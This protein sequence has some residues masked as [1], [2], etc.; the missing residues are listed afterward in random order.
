[1]AGIRAKVYDNFITR[2]WPVQSAPVAKFN[3]VNC[4]NKLDEEYA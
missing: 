4:F 2:P 3:N 1:M